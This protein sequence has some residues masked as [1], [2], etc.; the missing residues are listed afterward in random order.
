VAVSQE[1]AEKGARAVAVEYTDDVEGKAIVSIEEA[2][3]AESFWTDFR[4]EMK[5]GGNV[6]DILTV[7]EVDGKRLVVVEGSIRSGGQEHFYLEPNSTLAV[8]S[9]SATNLTIYA[10]TQAPTKTQDFCARVT[11]TPAAKVVVRMKRMGCSGSGEID[12]PACP[13]D[14]ES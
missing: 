13:R 4:H 9:E 1:I 14:S 11:N 2:I 3:N 10:S 8:P 6:D 5:R 7:S 12:E